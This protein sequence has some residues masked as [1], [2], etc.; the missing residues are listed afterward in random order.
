V[1]FK[2]FPTPESLLRLLLPIIVKCL[3]SLSD[4]FVFGKFCFL[5]NSLIIDSALMVTC[6][7]FIT[8][9]L[10]HSFTYTKIC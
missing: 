1:C 2:T 4:H 5:F 9:L 7:V 10:R 3:G 8:V 6:V